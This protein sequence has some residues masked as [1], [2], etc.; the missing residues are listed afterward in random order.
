MSGDSWGVRGQLATG[1]RDR[2][3]RSLRPG[4][5]FDFDTT[6]APALDDAETAGGGS[7]RPTWEP[8]GLV[9]LGGRAWRFPHR[10]VQPPFESC[11]GILTGTIMTRLS[12]K[13][14]R[15]Q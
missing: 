8:P 7:Q 13:W 2:P 5:V 9:T 11:T 3:P 10:S 1:R 6:S 14:H 15:Q 4:R 12:P